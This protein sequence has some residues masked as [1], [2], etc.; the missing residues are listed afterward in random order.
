MSPRILHFAENQVFWE[1]NTTVAGEAFPRSL[2]NGMTY[3]SMRN[4]ISS[5]ETPLQNWAP[6][7]RDYTRRSLSYTSDKLPAISGVAEILGRR[8][9]GTYHCGIW[10]NGDILPQLA[11]HVDSGS[12]IRRPQ[13]PRAPSWSWAS[14]DSPV[15]LPEWSREA[16]YPIAKIVHCEAGT[17]DTD[18]R[19]PVSGLLIAEGPLEKYVPARSPDDYLPERHRLVKGKDKVLLDTESCPM[20]NLYRLPLYEESYVDYDADRHGASVIRAYDM[21]L[22]PDDS[23]PST[24]HRCGLTM[25]HDLFG[26]RFSTKVSAGLAVGEYLD[27]ERGYRV[28]IM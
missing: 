14:V 10:T 7:L 17:D 24:L 18:P 21:L 28:R 16:L 26:R 9:G 6:V 4:I 5:E 1:C 3:H 8:W 2:V 20:D 13:P 15:S 23:D 22:T 19:K 25:T 11:W 12:G 27:S